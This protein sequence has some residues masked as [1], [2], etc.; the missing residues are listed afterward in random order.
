MLLC[1]CDQILE[2]VIPAFSQYLDTPLVDARTYYTTPNNYVVITL[3]DFLKKIGAE[4]FRLTKNARLG[5]CTIS[6]D[7][8]FM[9]Y[10]PDSSVTEAKDFVVLKTVDIISKQETVDTINF[11]ITSQLSAIP[12][13]AGTISD[14]Y[15]YWNSGQ[16][17][18]LHVLANDLFCNAIVD[19]SSLAITL[20]PKNGTAVV[21]NNRIVYT[22]PKEY[23]GSDLLYY[24]V[25]LKDDAG[26]ILS[27]A[28]RLDVR[29][30]SER[31]CEVR[32]VPNIYFMPKNQTQSL[33]MSVLDNDKLCY[34]Y[35][36]SS[37]KI[38]NVPSF[39]KAEINANAQIVYT[40]NANLLPLTNA[41]VY[42]SL[43]YTLNDLSGK[44][45][46]P[47]KVK[48]VLEQPPTCVEK[49]SNGKMEVSASVVGQQ[50]FEIPYSVYLSTCVDVLAVSVIT[51][52]KYGT[53]SISNNKK[54]YYTLKKSN[55]TA[56]QEQEETLSYVVYTTSGNA[57]TAKM[58]LKIKY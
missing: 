37:L 49:A 36:S 16:A 29:G 52:P 40:L 42:D 25:K 22:A 7:G 34:S 26:T 21:K 31:L 20:E 38:T 15:K 35:P 28:V 4:S 50:A 55:L 18:T 10:L 1:G 51:E 3:K 56:G 27:A 53:L 44:V 6:S 45:S 14:F 5:N 33:V 58:Q 43:Y 17:I 30:S 39:G 46:A 47:V 32:L 13:N 24:S 54:I 2:G 19:S 48:I 9:L 12:C 8:K 57:L 11:Q 41:S 23:D